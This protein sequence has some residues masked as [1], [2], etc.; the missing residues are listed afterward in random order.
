MSG[1]RLGC[2]LLTARLPCGTGEIRYRCFLPDLTEFAAPS[3]TGPNYQQST[4]HLKNNIRLET[5]P[6][7]DTVWFESL[8]LYAA[9]GEGGIRTLGTLIRGTHDFQSCTFNRSVTSPVCH[10]KNLRCAGLLYRQSMSPKCLHCPLFLRIRQDLSRSE[11]NCQILSCGSGLRKVSTYR[12]DV[13]S[14][15]VEIGNRKSKSTMSSD[16]SVCPRKHVRWNRQAD[17]LRVDAA[18]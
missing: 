18:F 7:T 11:L 14:P 17:L 9:G 4:S 13:F 5:L 6:F 10:F 16:D 2:P 12:V 15:Q 1:A 3:C 8:A